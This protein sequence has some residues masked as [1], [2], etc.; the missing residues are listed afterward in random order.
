[1]QLHSTSGK[2][3]LGLALT[4]VSV[5]LWG[6]LPIALKITLQALD[7]YTLTWFRFL[8][9]FTLVGIYLT[10]RNKL[11]PLE[12]LRSTSPILIA[13]ATL[14]LALNYLFF[15]KGLSLTSPANAQ[16]IMQLAPVFMGLG[17]LTIFKEKYSLTQWVGVGILTLGLSLFF[18]QQLKTLIT[19]PSQYL[20]GCSLIVIAAIVWA[21]YALAQKQ[22]LKQL[23]SSN[24]MLI[25]YGGCI[26]LFT[27]TATPPTILNINY[28]HWFALI[29]CCLNT[30]FAYGSFAE[31]L[32]HWE[33]SKI[34]ALLATTP[35]VTLFTA[36]LISLLIPNL[37]SP[38]KLT[39]LA[40]FGAVLVVVGSI[41]I[42]LGQKR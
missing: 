20:L 13:I 26:L 5:I 6:S 21:I 11:P 33:A 31:A 3:H 34:S 36:W 2:W 24:I 23:P 22:L 17:G 27:P 28:L 7:V 15:L 30:V 37:I 19:A 35:V 10:T 1:M 8:V 12:K 42:A 32:E 14:F 25:I 40:L 41:T 9:S 38:E 29:F 18:N 16:V 39:V 4:L